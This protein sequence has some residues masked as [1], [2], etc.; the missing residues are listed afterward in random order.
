MVPERTEQH[1]RVAAVERLLI[2]LNAFHHDSVGA[3]VDASH[4]LDSDRQADKATP[5]KHRWERKA[6][7]ETRLSQGDIGGADRNTIHGYRDMLGCAPELPVQR[8]TGYGQ[9]LPRQ[10]GRAYRD[11]GR[12]WHPADVPLWRLPL[13]S[14]QIAV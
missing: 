2:Y 11:G 7:N 8:I 14:E 1:D 4:R 10:I 5:D 3:A 13:G 12:V 9:L 6:A